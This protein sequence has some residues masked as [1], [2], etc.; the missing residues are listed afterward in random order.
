[1]VGGTV[2]RDRPAVG[3]QFSGVI[4]DHDPVAEQ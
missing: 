3:Q 2:R 1:M 4:E